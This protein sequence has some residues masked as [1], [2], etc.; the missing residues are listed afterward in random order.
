MKPIFAAS[1]MCMDFLNVARDM[2]IINADCDMYHADIMDGHFAKN[3]TCS[4]DFIKAI[5]RAT[6]L[7]IDAHLMVEY[8]NDFIDAV[9]KA[10]V[11]YIS[12]HA[13]TINV[14]A[15]RTINRIKS[16]GKKVG[17]ALNPATPIDYI[18]HY[19][20]E[21]DLLTIMTVDIG[22]GGQ[23]YIKVMEKKVA[24][25]RDLREKEGYKYVIQIDGS[26]N[27]VT[28]AGLAAAGAEAFVMGSTGLFRKGMA[29]NESA[30]LMRKEYTELTGIDAARHSESG[31]K[32]VVAVDVGGTNIRLGMV[33]ENHNISAFTKVFRE[34]VMSG[35]NPA[36][37]LG[38]YIESYI[39]KNCAANMPAAVAVGVPST[40]DSA[41]RTVM[42][43]P[44]IP[45]MDNIPLAEKLESRLGIPAFI[46]R[47]VTLLFQ[48]DY[49]K[50]GLPAKGIAI[51]VYLG[52][53]LGNA[54][55]VDGQPLIGA[56]GA[57]GE[58][59]HI[60]VLG[61]DGVCGCGN[62]GCIE[63][64][65]GGK[66]LEKIADE[67][68]VPIKKIFAERGTGPEVL[69]YLDAVASAVA[70]AVNILNPAAVVLGG[71]VPTMERFPSGKLEQLILSYTRKPY[72]AQSLKI[73][74]SEDGD[75]NGVIG[76]GIFAHK[77]L[78][79]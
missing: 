48:N 74:W 10:G 58:I 11:D 66:Y 72:P 24:E 2:Q 21:V 78:R 14:N 33:D 27:P 67:M 41:R 13:E 65:A 1:I 45:G 31:G 42:S 46:E 29:L 34:E 64:F 62:S 43:T 75:M 40:I 50:Y 3:I 55:Y 18:R 7:P 38:E 70:S 73:T 56:D 35:E 79:G 5:R 12:L 23:P 17:I 44:N 51:G 8:P 53:G 4:P 76:G 69:K 20:H 36:D 71:G 54:I 52:T 26:C 47:D 19:I 37:G 16:L 60:P 63:L 59:G 9:A 6:D 15:F 68:N 30:L 61:A 57:A 28:Y 25:A 39:A 49:E 22:F 32:I 77:K